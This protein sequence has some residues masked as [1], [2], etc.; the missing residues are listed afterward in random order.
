MVQ[1]LERVATI[2]TILK[3]QNRVLDKIESDVDIL[4]M[5]KAGRD[6]EKRTVRK[7]AAYVSAL[8]AAGIQFV[9]I[10]AQAYWNSKK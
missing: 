4:V 10:A 7:M 8:T 3:N 9:G 2:E 5:D 1:M 6:A